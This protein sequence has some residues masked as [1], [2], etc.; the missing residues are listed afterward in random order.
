[1]GQKKNYSYIYQKKN[2]TNPTNI[3]NCY[4]DKIFILM[5][6]FFLSEHE[7]DKSDYNLKDKHFKVLYLF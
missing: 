6:I 7:E 1:M 2:S 5:L 3:N 4:L